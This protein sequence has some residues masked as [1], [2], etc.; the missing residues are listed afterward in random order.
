MILF[1]SNDSLEE[2]KYQNK[3]KKN[4]FYVIDVIYNLNK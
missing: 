3:N 4:Y 2:E 1:I